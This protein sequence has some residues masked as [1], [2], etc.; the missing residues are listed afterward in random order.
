MLPTSTS[1]VELERNYT[2]LFPYVLVWLKVY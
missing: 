1:I 2:Q